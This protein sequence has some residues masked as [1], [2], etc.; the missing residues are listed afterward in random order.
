MSGEQFLNWEAYAQVEPFGSWWSSQL[1]ASVLCFLANQ[2]RNIKKRPK[3]YEVK[4]FLLMLSTEPKRKQTWQEQKQI[5]TIIAHA[6]SH[7]P[8]GGEERPG[9][10]PRRRR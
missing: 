1:V 2:S 7:P 8:K 6:H 3:P 9:S 5:M 4:D 10:T